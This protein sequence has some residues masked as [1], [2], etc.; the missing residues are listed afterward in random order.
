MPPRQLRQAVVEPV[1]LLYHQLSQA[2]VA[3]LAVKGGLAVSTPRRRAP[4]AVVVAVV[5]SESTEIRAM[6]ST[7]PRGLPPLLLL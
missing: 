5:E 4:V 3:R 6:I 2:A 1:V 7:Q